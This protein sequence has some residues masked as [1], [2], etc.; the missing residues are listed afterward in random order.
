[1]LPYLRWKAERRG[2][3]RLRVVALPA[4]CS[5]YAGS[6]RM[7]VDARAVTGRFDAIVLA[8]VLEH[9]LDPLRVLI[10][11]LGRLRPGGIAFVNYPADVDGD[12]HTPEAWHQRRACFLLL[13][14]AC[15]SAGGHAWRRRRDPLPFAARAL[16]R[17]AEPWLRLASRRYAR[18][19]FR[20]RGD[21]LVARVRELSGRE[22][23]VQDLLADV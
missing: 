23:R 15:R 1:M 21:S 2:D 18:R 4:R 6:A 17:G 8:D 7:R 10:H 16:A 5:G 12:W 13:R 19:L 14:S 22:L 20:E 3:G 11:L 9:T